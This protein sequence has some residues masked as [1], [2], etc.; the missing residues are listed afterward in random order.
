[1]KKKSRCFWKCRL[2]KKKA[3]DGVQRGTLFLFQDETEAIPEAT[4]S[5]REEG[6]PWRLPKCIRPQGFRGA[7]RLWIFSAGHV[8]AEG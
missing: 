8:G 1:M 7:V 6:R 4:C 3:E 2:M 5:G